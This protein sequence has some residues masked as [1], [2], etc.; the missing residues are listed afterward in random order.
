MEFL[1]FS[2]VFNSSYFDFKFLLQDTLEY[3]LTDENDFPASYISPAI[4]ISAGHSEL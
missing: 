1:L 4:V 2:D 3:H